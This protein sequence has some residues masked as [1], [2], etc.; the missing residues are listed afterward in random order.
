M[1][2]TEELHELRDRGLS[3]VAATDDLASLDAVRVEFLGKKGSLTAILRGLGAL[4]A[5]GAARRR[6]GVQ[7]SSAVA[8]IG[9]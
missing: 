2:I 3:A 8:R 6:Q 4:S 5:R 1:G 7:R 9:V